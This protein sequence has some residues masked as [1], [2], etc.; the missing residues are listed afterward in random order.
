MSTH[1]LSQ[2][3]NQNLEVS[4]S[5]FVN[6]YRVEYAMRRIDDPSSRDFTLVAIAREAGFS[7]K[8]SFNR[9]FKKV[10]GKTPSEYQK[11]VAGDTESGGA[12]TIL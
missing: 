8:T 11:G 2:L 7:S 10:T 5:D 3:L 6:R 9:A 1:N 12:A 4:F